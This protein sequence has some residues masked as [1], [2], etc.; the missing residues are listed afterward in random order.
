MKGTLLTVCSLLVA[1]GIFAGMV[2]YTVSVLRQYQWKI[3][4]GE[5]KT[6]ASYAQ[7]EDAPSPCKMHGLFLYP[8]KPSSLNRKNIPYR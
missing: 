3:L 6:A 8:V 5:Y 4:T 1:V 7:Q 2:L